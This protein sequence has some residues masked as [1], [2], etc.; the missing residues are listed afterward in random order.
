MI[1][2][3]K[4]FDFGYEFSEIFD[5]SSVHIQIRFTY[6]QYTDRFIPRIPLYVQIHSA[7]LVNVPK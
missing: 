6:S 2:V 3:L 7:Y 1:D 5:F 4:C